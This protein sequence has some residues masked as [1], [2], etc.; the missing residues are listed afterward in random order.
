MGIDVGLS[1]V[2]RIEVVFEEVNNEDITVELVDNPVTIELETP[3]EIQVAV[4]EIYSDVNV[5][6]DHDNLIN[7]NLNKQHTAETIQESTS[8]RF[9]SDTEIDSKANQI[10]LTNHINNLNNP[11]E[12][13]LS[14]LEGF[15]ATPTR[16]KFLRDDKTFAEIAV[17][18]GGYAA[19]VYLTN[20][21]SD[22]PTYK[23]ISYSVESTETV[24]S[25]TAT[26]ESKLV[27]NYIYDSGVGVTTLDSGAWYFFFTCKLDVVNNSN[28]IKTVIF[29]RDISNIETDLITSYSSELINTDYLQIRFQNIQQNIPVLATDR[30]GIRVYFET[31]NTNPVTFNLKVDDGSASYFTTP[32][33]LSHNQLRRP[34]E[35]LNV[36]HLTNSE[37]FEGGL[38]TGVSSPS[39]FTGKD[40]STLN[41][42][43]TEFDIEINNNAKEDGTVL[44]HSQ[45]WTTAGSISITGNVVT[46]TGTAFTS[47]M[48]GAKLKLSN[49][50]YAI[51]IR[52]TNGSNITISKN[53]SETVTVANGN[54][55]IN[56]KAVELGISN[57]IIFRS[58]NGILIFKN[59]DTDVTSLRTNSVSHD[60][61]A[62]AFNASGLFLSNYTYLK[63]SS[64]ATYYGVRDIGIKRNSAGILEINDGNTA[65]DY[66]DLN[67]R[68]L[69]YTGALNNTSDERLKTGFKPFT[70]AKDKVLKLA[71]CVKHFEY[72]DQ[73]NYAEGLRTDFI[74]QL[75]QA[76]GFEGHVTE[77]MPKDENE[78]ILFGWTYKDEEYE[79][80][81][82]QGEIEVKIRHIVDQQGDMV[83]QI[84]KNFIPHIC[85]AYAE[86]N[87]EHEELK[88]RLF[89]IEKSLGLA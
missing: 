51:I 35:D 87:K 55:S 79:E 15:P 58:Y 3:P 77:R 2:D 29:K 9:T 19:N 7:R 38:A 17:G 75:L 49:G 57:N 4:N 5:I 52:Y 50:W 26:N 62:Y 27:Y 84:E 59:I 83:L 81:N 67:L 54:W 53:V 31:T 8:K 74:A 64:N 18:S 65:G 16:T 72:K 21:D 14:N 63:F 32:L 89:N 88:Q 69:N 45:P 24:I 11:H 86:L 76:N 48:V 43:A 80:T 33:V 56:S 22:I 13:D 68:N 82:E 28:R 61:N 70:G 10:D 71:E 41:K 34:N 30:I 42:L 6:L 12:T 78:G 44:Y 20:I 23:K 25:T 47:A 39:Q 85:C 40:I 73:N 1:E 66:R 37:R 36:Q 60:G 46:G